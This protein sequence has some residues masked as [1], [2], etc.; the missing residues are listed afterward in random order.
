MGEESGGRLDEV[1]DRSWP[2]GWVEEAEPQ[3][4]DRTE[5]STDLWV[6]HQTSPRTLHN[7]ILRDPLATV[8]NVAN[9]TITFPQKISVGLS[10]LLSYIYCIIQL[11]YLLIH[12]S[13]TLL[14][15]IT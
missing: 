11:L 15:I 1:E 8:S 2:V 9:H 5:P 10:M 13:L 7:S 14:H 12:S 3:T 4:Y 6:K